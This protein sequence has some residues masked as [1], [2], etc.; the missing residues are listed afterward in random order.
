MRAAL[1]A[2][3]VLILDDFVSVMSC[4]LILEE[5]DFAFWSPS[6]VVTQRRD[7]SPMSRLSAARVSETT[8][9]QW[10]SS[11]LL[12]EI[13]QVESRLCRRLQVRPNHLERWQATRYRRGGKFEAHFDGGGL[14]QREAAGDREVSVLVYL[15]TPAAG[16]HTTFPE[17]GLDLEPRAGT[18]VAWKNLAPDG[19]VDPRSKH[20]ARPVRTGH[21]VVLTTWSRQQPVRTSPADME[22]Q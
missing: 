5:L 7:G 6:T 11:Q 17:L 22:V 4:R 10:F 9:E 1:E 12:R 3:T 14:F 16:G 2:G 13:R 21:K 8:G 15:N 19:T 18:V 20:L